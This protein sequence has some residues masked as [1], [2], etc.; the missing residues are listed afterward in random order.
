MDVVTGFNAFQFAPDM[1]AA[2][3][4]AARVTRAGGQV[5]VCNWSASAPGELL[6][7]IHML[8]GLQPEPTLVP[9]LP[10]GEPGV[11]EAMLERAGLRP[12]QAAEVAVPW[13]PPDR[14]TLERGLLSAGNIAPSVAHA[15]EEAVRAAIVEACR[16]HRR[17]DGSYQFRDTFRYVVAGKPAR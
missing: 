4:E 17:G 14:Q 11:L 10:I 3:A 13:A 15:G 6:A 9:R 5:A 12:R 1:V 2:L 7:V 8:Q 16:P